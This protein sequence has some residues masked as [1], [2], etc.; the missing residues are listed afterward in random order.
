MSQSNADSMLHSNIYPIDNNF[1]HH[2]TDIEGTPHALNITQFNGVVSHGALINSC[3][4]K[5]KQNASI[6]HRYMCDIS[7]AEAFKCVK[8]YA[9][10]TA[11]ELTHFLDKSQILWSHAKPKHPNWSSM[12]IKKVFEVRDLSSISMHNMHLLKKVDT[13][14][15]MIDHQNLIE[16]KVTFKKKSY[17]K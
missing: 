13:I 7:T 16:S 6:I 2:I 17:T 9:Q 5:C 3:G 11:D 10:I 15:G 1:F 4:N 8:N 14:R 12:S